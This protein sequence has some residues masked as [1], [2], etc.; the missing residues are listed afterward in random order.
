MLAAAPDYRFP[1]LL[2]EFWEKA[3]FEPDILSLDNDTARKVIAEE[4]RQRKV[5]STHYQH[6]DGTSFAAPITASVVAQML[7]ANPALTPAAI[8]HIL[9][10]TAIKLAGHPAVRQGFGILNA[11]LA[12][13]KALNE[14]H[15][16]YAEYFS[17]PRVAGAKILFF[18]HDDTADSVSLAGDLNEWDQKKT[19]FVKNSQG[20]WQA[21]IPCLP[22][23][24]YRYKFLVNGNHWTE[25]ISH[26]LKEEDDFGGFNSLLILE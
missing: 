14:S 5:V 23:G 25:D 4:L 2:R 24:K 17:P 20:V 9:V 21:E 11:K 3:G 19:R 15:S 7:E 1:L 8:K 6:V 18:Y 12:V 16:L 10:S 26:G 13:E 22:P